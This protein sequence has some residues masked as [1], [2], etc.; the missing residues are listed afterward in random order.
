MANG[1]AHILDGERNMS[2]T[3]RAV[4]VA[5]GLG[6]AAASVGRP[7]PVLGFAALLGGAALAVRGLYGHCPV[8]AA[9]GQGETPRQI[10][11]H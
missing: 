6:L 8:K 2:M 4:S 1:L 11:Y 7:N 5:L 9:L 3:E 10:A